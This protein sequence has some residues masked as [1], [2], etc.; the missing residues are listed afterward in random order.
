MTP[1]LSHFVW[2]LPPEG[3]NFSWGGP[4]F[5]KSGEAKNCLRVPTIL[6]ERR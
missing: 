5:S 3:V 1:T 2:S 4:V 6:E